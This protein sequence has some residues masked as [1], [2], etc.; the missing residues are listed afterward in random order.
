MGLF[1]A[2]KPLLSLFFTLF[3]LFSLFATAA[4][5][6]VQAASFDGQ[7][8][9]YKLTLSADGQTATVEASLWLTSD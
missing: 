3:G 9:H 4:I 5:S 2:R 1:T 8:N 6:P 7:T